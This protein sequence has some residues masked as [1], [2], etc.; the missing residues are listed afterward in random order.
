MLIADMVPFIPPHAQL[1]RVVSLAILLSLGALVT[2]LVLSMR[3]AVKVTALCVIA[4]IV[5]AGIV[6]SGS[7]NHDTQAEFRT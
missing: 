1:L 3:R 2:V 6:V 4:A 5:V 7:L